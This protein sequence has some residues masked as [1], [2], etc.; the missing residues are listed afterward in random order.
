MDDR[1]PSGQ[2]LAVPVE[3]SGLA[4][5]PSR[6]HLSHDQIA[7]LAMCPAGT[8][9]ASDIPWSRPGPTGNALNRLAQRG[10]LIQ[11][12]DP[13]KWGRSRYA[14]SPRGYAIAMETQRAETENTGSVAKP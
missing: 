12:S 9:V 3:P 7:L 13:A 8:F 2:A 1:A 10:L 6:E 14:L 11:A 4:P 5:S